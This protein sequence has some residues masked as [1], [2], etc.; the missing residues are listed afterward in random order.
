MNSIAIIVLWEGASTALNRYLQSCFWQLAPADSL[1]VVT[2]AMPALAL[3]GVRTFPTLGASVE[4]IT[5][6]LVIVLSAPRDVLAPFVLQQLR[7]A[8]ISAGA[9]LGPRR[10]V[11]APH[12][13]CSWPG[14]GLARPI[15]PP[16]SVASQYAFRTDR[17]RQLVKELSWAQWPAELF[18]WLQQHGNDVVLIPYPIAHANLG[19]TDP[20]RE[21]V[22]VVIPVFKEPAEFIW[23]AVASCYQQ[24]EE[25]EAVIVVPGQGVEADL[26]FIERYGLT[27]VR[28]L[29]DPDG[30]R[31]GSCRNQGIAAATTPW[32]KFLDGDDVLAP[33]ALQAL[34]HPP[35]A[36][37]KVLYGCQVFMIDGGYAG[38]RDSGAT[39]IEGIIHANPLIPSCT[40]VRRQAVIEAGGFDPR[41]GFEEDYDLWLR[42]AS[43]HGLEAFAA[44]PQLFDYYWIDTARRHAAV[45]SRDY[46]VEGLAVRDYFNAKYG[47][48][49]VHEEDQP[50]AGGNREAGW[51]VPEILA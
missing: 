47:I 43:R 21:K 42:L 12:C 5:Q 49:C 8:E 40:L 9:L 37:V 25:D 27:G 35:P 46:L 36:H 14:V 29:P 2:G 45:Q 28:V 16:V 48:Q 24:L 51:D 22:C 3:P 15:G 38:V 32:V 41:L 44:H 30:K 13:G 4:A 11:S 7:S 39:R 1:R 20:P 34:C 18:P 10:W 23:R 17:L 26:S 6:D 19:A 31:V 50:K 33:F